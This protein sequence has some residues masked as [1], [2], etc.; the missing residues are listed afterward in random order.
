AGYQEIVLTGIHL[1]D[2]HPDENEHLDL[3][4]LIATLL[5]ETEMPRI[6]VS[7][8]EPEDFRLEW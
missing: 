1:G 2:Y 7:S 4:D 5:K 8:L 3:G 6:R